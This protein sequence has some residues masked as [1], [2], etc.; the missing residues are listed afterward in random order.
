MYTASSG[1]W[2][3]VW[4][5]TV[6]HTYIES[7]TMTPDVD[8][9]QLRLEVNLTGDKADCIIQVTARS[10]AKIVAKSNVTGPRLCASAT[11]ICGRPMIR[12]CT[13]FKY[14]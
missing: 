8:Q 5:E 2:Q 4:L 9:S 1:I 13:T 12:S 11:L 14:A 6:P 3:T 7:L 10:G